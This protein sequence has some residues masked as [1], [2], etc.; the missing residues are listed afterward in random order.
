MPGLFGILSLKPNSTS[1]EENRI[2]FTKM[3]DTL[4]HH[5]DDRLEQAYVTGSNLLIGRIGLAHQDSISWPNYPYGEET[6][7]RMFVSGP[8]LERET[9]GP[10][11]RVP[12]NTAF[13]HWHGFFSAV[14][15]EPTRGTTL[16][17]VDRRAS[18]PIYYVQIRDQLLFAPEVKALLA[19]PFFKKEID[20]GAFAT[21][22]A[23]GFLLGDQTLFKSARRLRG[24]EL[25]RVENGR[26]V[27]E[28]YW[29]FLP[30]SVPSDASQA[31]LECELGQL[32]NAAAGKHMGEP[33][34][35]IIF[36]SGGVD[37]RGILGGALTNVQGHGEKLNTVCWGE[38]QGAKDSDVAIAALM[39]R[40]L[41]T[42]HRF[43]QRKITNFRENFR[44]VN[45]LIDG[46][47]DIAAFHPHEYQ[48]MAELRNSGIER[49]LR[50]DEVFGLK[51]FSA[52]TIEGASTVAYLSRLRSVQRLAPVIRETHYNE[53]CEASDAAVERALS[54]A[55]DLSPNQ[56]KDFFYFNHRL[57]CYLQT[58]SYYKQIE[59]D[60]RNILL[61]DQILNFLAKVPDSLRVDKMLFRQVVI[62]EYPLLAQFPYAKQGNLEDWPKLLSTD[63]P[64][65]EYALEELRDRTSG[66][67]EFLDPDALTKVIGTLGKG[68]GFHSILAQRL[69]PKSLVRESLMI[70]APRLLAQIRS[71]RRARPV[72]RL[73][74]DKIIMRSLV[75]KNWYDTFV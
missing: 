7:V 44:H 48:I 58:A 50:G 53:F 31:D 54:E 61:D 40:H 29:R 36:L 8:L 21:F 72:V 51:Y 2:I 5:G 46:L 71:Q 30:G 74:V 59:M 25:L 16:L 63:S 38:S 55:R 22:L 75:L 11:S 26:V 62:R 28:T 65:R 45:Y 57:Q 10:I 47:S 32:L 23:Q 17:M 15:A 3:A 41:N 20:L 49:V 12:E 24:G 13:R 1:G 18:M 42:K 4:R 43:M 60:H 67:W 6:G 73:G 39:A 9:D 52:S 37:S 34:K 35:T 64:V 33:E 69:N 14:L 66:I 70:F 56:A 19:S 68:F 27:K